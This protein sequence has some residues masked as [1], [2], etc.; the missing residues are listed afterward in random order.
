MGTTIPLGDVIGI[1]ENILLKAVIPLQRHFNPNA[2]LCGGLAM[3]CFIY[4]VLALIEEVDKS[5]QAAVIGIGF[6][7][8]RSLIRQLNTNPAVEESQLPQAFAQYVEVK[9]NIG[10]GFRRGL[11]ANRSPGSLGFAHNSK[12]RLRHAMTVYLLVEFALATDGELQM[13]GKRVDHR[14]PHPMQPTRDFVGVVVKFSAGMEYRH[15]DFRC[16]NTLLMHLGG[17]APAVI[18]NAHRLIGVNHD[19]NF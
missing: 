13:F 9:L 10:K 6:L 12:G 1:A 18:G 15:N 4:G 3:K 2:T 11:E 19:R 17:D 7:L 14:N 16:R 5:I 8:T